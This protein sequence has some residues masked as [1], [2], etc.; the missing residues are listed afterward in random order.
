MKTRAI[1]FLSFLCLILLGQITV[2]R[3]SEAQVPRSLSYQGVLADAS[4]NFVPDGTHS[5]E[6]NLYEAATGGTAIHTETVSV[7][8]VRGLFNAIIGQSGLPSSI[9]F[10]KAYF[11]GVKVDGSAELTP[12]T[13]L[14]AVPYALRADVATVAE[15]LAPSVTGVVQTVNGKSGAITLQG[16]GSTTVSSSGNTIT[17]SSSGSGGGGG[18]NAIE[19]GDGALA[20]TTAG[21]IATLKVKDFGITGKML[22]VNS[23]LTE[24][25]YP[26]AVTTEKLRDS[27]V[28]GPKLHDNAVIA[29]KIA[30]DAVLTA[31][32][33]DGAVTDKKL[34]ADAVTSAKIEDGTIQGT[35]INS[36][37]TLN[38]SSVS[39]L[40]KIGINVAVPAA[41]LE[42]K[43]FTTTSAGASLNVMDNA[44]TSML[45]VRDDGNVGIGTNSPGT[46][47][48]IAAPNGVALRVAS[49]A[50][51]LSIANITAG[52]TIAIN[53]TASFYEI[54]NDG[55][56]APNVLN[57]GAGMP[58]QLLYIFNTDAQATAGMVSIASNTGVTLIFD[59]A[60][61]RVVG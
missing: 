54:M 16:S 51:V 13:P 25:L 18:I 60:F 32:I 28:T 1:T 9:T 36:G 35:D 24:K 58:G 17:I 43:G 6:I 39:T 53:P 41:M 46:R 48:E 33:L 2:V 42:V 47:L 26:E 4:G 7:P 44:G 61:W 45:F 5:L 50:T 12:R 49:G 34:A 27:S 11:V 8:V 29:G 30:K 14:S 3:V 37:A 40:G 56:A 10:N 52:P 22:A 21:P 57:I 59:G 20:I 55:V 38:V 31:N 15:G 23:V 19:S